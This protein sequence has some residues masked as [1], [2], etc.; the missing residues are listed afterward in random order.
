MNDYVFDYHQYRKTLFTKNN[1]SFVII[2]LIIIFLL[3]L[4][5]FLKPI[6]T[7]KT[8]FYFVEIDNFQTY[9][10]AQI[11]SNE[12]QNLNTSPLIYFDKSYHVLIGFY[13]SK[14]SAETVCEKLKNDYSNSTVFE[15]GFLKN[16]SYKNLSKT[17]NS[18][19][20]N[21]I[22]TTYEITLKIENL[23]N[24]F[25]CKKTTFNKV[26]IYM[27]EQNEICIE[28]CDDFFEAFKTDSIFNSIKP[29]VSNIVNSL[30][31]IS[32]LNES[33]FSSQCRYE[34]MNIAINLSQIANGI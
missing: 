16:F 12:L 5:I 25:E 21:L 8:T 26:K 18:C 28:S 19:V 14:K 7:K 31:S 22:K 6:Q 29:H 4:C 20:E 27:K 24:N 11:L 32:N 9:K 10:H 3:S 23:L 13:S 1:F 17:Q 34:L 30:N 33:N 2:F 15:L